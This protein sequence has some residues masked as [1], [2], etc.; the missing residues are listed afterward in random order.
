MEKEPEKKSKKDKRITMSDPRG[1]Y[2]DKITFI[3]ESIGTPYRGEVIRRAI[4]DLFQQYSKKKPDY[5]LLEEKRLA[6]RKEALARAAQAGEL[7]AS[8]A[9]IEKEA[10]EEL[11][12]ERE[13]EK[14]RRIC[15]D[16]GGEVIQTPG[17]FAC[18]YKNYNLINPYQVQVS[19]MREPFDTLSVSN[20]QYQYQGD[21]K[22]EIERVL[23]EQ[24]KG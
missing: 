22:E 4:D 19:D 18:Q 7:D 6:L 3:M 2:Y 13:H 24:L 12:K 23:E 16:L 5:V 17:G 8:E 20:L 10:R 11:R 21:T 1:L 14:K 9:L 15:E